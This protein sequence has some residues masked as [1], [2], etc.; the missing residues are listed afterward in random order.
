MEGVGTVDDGDDN[1]DDEYSPNTFII[2]WKRN[3]NFNVT[4]NLHY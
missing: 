2:T 1:N 4:R 3:K